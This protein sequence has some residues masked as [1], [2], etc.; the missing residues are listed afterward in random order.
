MKIRATLRKAALPVLTVLLALLTATTWVFASPV[1][2]GPDDD[3]HLA[4]SWC[5]GPAAQQSCLP[6]ADGFAFYRVPEALI[7]APCFA[8]EPEQSAVCQDRSLDWSSSDLVETGRLNSIGA[9]PPVFYAVTGVFSGEDVQAASLIM[10]GVSVILFLALLVLLFVLLP[11]HRRPTL[12]WAFLLTAIPLGVFLFGTNNPSLW[13]WLGVGAAPVALLGYYETSGRR[14][15]AL[16]SLFVVSAV[17]A[18]GSRSDA[19]IYIGIAIVAVALL[20]FA[21]RAAFYRDSILPAL[22]ALASFGVFVST[23]LARR[24]IGGFAGQVLDQEGVPLPEQEAPDGNTAP[25]PPTDNGGGA[26]DNNLSGFALLASNLLNLPRLWMGVFGE[27]WGLGWLDTTMPAIVPA[28]TIAAFVLVGTVG[29]SR[30]GWRRAAAIAG[31]VSTLVVIPLAALQAGG[32]T[33]GEQV[34]PRYLLPLVA[35]LVVIMTATFA[36]GELALTRVHRF[37][38][39]VALSVAHFVALHMNLRRYVTGI[40]QPGPNLDAGAEWWWGGPIGPTA[41]WLLGSLAFTI[42]AAVLVSGK[43]FVVRSLPSIGSPAAPR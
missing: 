12:A 3:Y 13:A 15:A 35:L 17:V 1:G 2:A 28:A 42:L 41:L 9:Y 32:F 14:K 34:Q 43:P 33:V 31:V 18:A 20:S 39:V 29:M 26:G 5:A 4:S 40:D 19:A 11:V 30:L 24:G 22:V 7:A 16:G 36:G 21:N 8:F 10:R 37:L 25:M 38:V 23:F 6:P 27:Q